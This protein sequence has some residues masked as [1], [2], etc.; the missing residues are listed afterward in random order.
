MMPLAHFV[1]MHFFREIDRGSWNY[2]LF[3][4]E[5]VGPCAVVMSKNEFSG[6]IRKDCREKLP[7]THPCKID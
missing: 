7:S 5:T 1:T 2:L 3:F 4:N 6:I